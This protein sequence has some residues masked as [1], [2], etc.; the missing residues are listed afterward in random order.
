MQQLS[1][2][3][4]D[5]ARLPKKPYCSNDLSHGLLIRPLHQALAMRYIQP[6]R[7]GLQHYLAFDLDRPEAGA[8]WMDTRVPKPS[9]VIKNPDNGHCHY[10]Y[11]L[12]HPVCTTDA[13]R[14]KPLRY[15]AALE[16]AMAAEMGADP[17]YSGLIIKNPAHQHWQTIVLQARPYSL[18]DLALN[19]DL[20]SP[21]NAAAYSQ[22]AGLGRNCSVFDGLRHW[23]YRA[24]RH[25]W[26][27]GGEAAWRQAVRTKAH[28]LNQF[29]EPLQSKE[30]DQIAK[31]VGK[32]VW[33]HFNPHEL[34]DLIERT[35]TPELQSRRG[36][37]KGKALRDAMLPE[38]FELAT[39]GLTQCD[40]AS[41]LGLQQRTV[42]NWLKRRD[43]NFSR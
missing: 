37:M 12:E 23:A 19:L 39:Q 35:H 31:S 6:N 11:A 30:I 27:P 40:I 9:F 42:S 16:R 25:H 5:S 14:V 21:A 10:L 41:R 34:R 4:F 36:Q 7:P 20:A 17:G 18:A 13:A 8:V 33:S 26:K 29:L 38:V 28:E 24:V 15:L 1:F 32:W 43:E 22:V 3:L 2:D